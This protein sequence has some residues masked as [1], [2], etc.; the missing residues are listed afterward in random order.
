MEPDEVYSCFKLNVVSDENTEIFFLCLQPSH[1]HD[2]RSDSSCSGTCWYSTCSTCSSFSCRRVRFR[3]TSSASFRP[4]RRTLQSVVCQQSLVDMSQ[5]ADVYLPGRLCE[6]LSE[7]T[8]RRSPP[9]E[10]WMPPAELCCSLA[11]QTS[12]RHKQSES[13]AYITLHVFILHTSKRRP[14]GSATQK[15]P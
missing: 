9:S 1:K 2:I 12:A 8:S 3:V 4:E 5:T 11:E 10:R 13:Y 7:W 15:W 6:C 14:V